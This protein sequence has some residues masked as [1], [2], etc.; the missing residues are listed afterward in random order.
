MIFQ[1]TLQ[2]INEEF[3]KVCVEQS[4]AYSRL[5]D[6]NV[7]EDVYSLLK[8]LYDEDKSIRFLD[9]YNATHVE[10]LLNDLLRSAKSKSVVPNAHVFL[11]RFITH[12]EYNLSLIGLIKQLEDIEKSGRSIEDRILYLLDYCII[13]ERTSYFQGLFISKLNSLNVEILGVNIEDYDLYYRIGSLNFKRHLYPEAIMSL[14]RAKKIMQNSAASFYSSSVLIDQVSFRKTLFK[15][16]MLIAVSYEYQGDFKT[17]LNLLIGE[18]NVRIFSNVQPDKMLYSPGVESPPV[19]EDS[20]LNVVITP[21]Q[22]ITIFN[23]QAE[24]IDKL[25]LTSLDD[26]CY[27]VAQTLDQWF[28]SLSKEQK[29]SIRFLETGNN[30]EYQRNEKKKYNQQYLYFQNENVHEVFHIVAHTLNEFG[31]AKRSRSLLSV[32]PNDDAEK[33]MVCARALMLYVAKK[34]NFMID[35]QKCL[36]CLATIYAEVGDYESA[37]AQ[38]I[39]NVNGN[40]YRNKDSLVQAEIE[41][42]YYLI[43]LMYNPSLSDSL[44]EE[45]Y[46]KYLKCCYNHFDYDAL[47]QIEM[48]RFKYSV[49]KFIIDI[50]ERDPRNA[51]GGQFLDFQIDYSKFIT[52]L[53]SVFVSDWTKNE[54]DKINVMFQFL[55]KYYNPDHQNESLSIVDLARKYLYLYGKSVKFQG[56]FPETLL[57][58]DNVEAIVNFLDK[59]FYQPVL[60]SYKDKKL[61]QIRNCIFQNISDMPFEAVD[62]IIEAA[63]NDG[64]NIYFL[65]VPHTYNVRRRAHIW[66]DTSEEKTL[67]NFMIHCAF[68]SILYDFVNPQNIFILVPFVNA[69]PLKYQ[70]D[71]FDTLLVKTGGTFADKVELKPAQGDRIIRIFRNNYISGNTNKWAK[72]IL[73]KFDNVIMILWNDEDLDSV[74]SKERFYLLNRH[75]HK[76]RCYPLMNYPAF[77]NTLDDL[78][79][80]EKLFPIHGHLSCPNNGECCQKIVYWQD[81]LPAKLNSYLCLNSFRNEQLYNS[82]IIVKL[83]NQKKQW[84]IVVT[85]NIISEHMLLLLR[86]YICENDDYIASQENTK[87]ESNNIVISSANALDAIR[88]KT[89]LRCKELYDDKIAW[90][91]GRERTLARESEAPVRA[92]YEKGHDEICELYGNVRVQISR[93]VSEDELSNIRHNLDHESQEICT[94]IEHEIKSFGK[95]AKNK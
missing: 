39:E 46:Q 10:T 65:T 91:E 18:E 29:K 38:L 54:Y 24:I 73:D 67:R 43:S 30:R 27:A 93:A 74:Y 84:R 79:N 63:I 42:F 80:E 62:K 32:E 5:N 89:S 45:F 44:S 81:G 12:I 78:V 31:V 71:S 75:L 26:S 37:R 17:A 11:E 15:I 25:K 88:E 41:F 6:Y 19:I 8:D 76:P 14:Q 47:S 16:N 59:V 4:E 86:A 51:T 36:S 21:E 48:Y 23:V 77:M 34:Q 49:A 87:Q 57:I 56:A 70:L 58:Q 95:G 83:N 1:D 82:Q 35:C 9:S 69:E 64:D 50:S 94:R 52:A 60:E 7:D 55:E 85:K 40:Y 72:Q 13:T 3:E 28:S 61:I 92:C 66:T 33:L 20:S 90:F 22:E 2:K 68:D 53:Q